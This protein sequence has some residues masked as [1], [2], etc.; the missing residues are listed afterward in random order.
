MPDQTDP[1]I[2]RSI[3]TLFHKNALLEFIQI[4][5]VISSSGTVASV[6]S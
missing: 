4:T 1:T 3:R 6:E 2:S 5:T